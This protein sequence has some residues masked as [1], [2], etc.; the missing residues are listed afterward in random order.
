MV[1]LWVDSML[2]ALWL[3]ARSGPPGVGVLASVSGRT[4]IASSRSSFV[5]PRAV[6]LAY[7]TRAHQRKDFVGSQLVSYEQ[8][9]RI[10]LILSRA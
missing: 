5:L 9:H 8:R 4:L 1:G 10:G 7:A 2:T 3:R 6:D